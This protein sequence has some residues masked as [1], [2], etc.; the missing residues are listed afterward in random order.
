MR[1]RLPAL[2]FPQPAPAPAAFTSEPGVVA[3]LTFGMYFIGGDVNALLI[4]SY[5]NAGSP[6]NSLKAA[7][8]A[9]G[10]IGVSF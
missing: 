10:Q 1:R 9:H 6:G 8:T 4:T 3:L 7:L 2:L 5:P